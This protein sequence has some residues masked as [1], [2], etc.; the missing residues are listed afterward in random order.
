MNSKGFSRL[1]NKVLGN[2]IKIA[3]ALGHISVGPEHLIVAIAE[4]AECDACAILEKHAARPL[5]E[6]RGELAKQLG[7]GEATR[8]GD[9]DVTAELEG[10]LKY[11]SVC[12][13]KLGDDCVGTEQLLCAAISSQNRTVLSL[14]SKL[15]VSAERVRGDCRPLPAERGP[16][17]FDYDKQRV[18]NKLLEK[19]T[20]DLTARAVCGKLDEV[21]CREEELAR[22]AAILSRRKK[23]NACLVGEPGVGKTAVAEG[24]AARIARGDVPDSLRGKRILSLDVSS[25][26]AGTKY[27]G[28][29]EE[30]FKTTISEIIKEGD[31]IVFID[32]MHTVMGA[33]AA[34]G[35]IDASNILKPLL[36]GSELQVIGATTLAEYAKYVEKDKAFERRFSRVDVPEPTAAQT[37]KI[38]DSQIP[39][40]ERFHSL[41]ISAAA[42]EAAVRLSVRYI[43]DRCLPDKALDLIDEAA[44]E[45]RI[46]LRESGRVRRTPV[47]DEQDVAR[48]V[49]GISGVP[50]G[51]LNTD[52]SARLLGL[53][54]SLR[55][56][57]IGQEDAVRTLSAAIRR[58]RSGLKEAEKPMGCF[59]FCGP[60][61]VGKT[62]VCRALA[63]EL[64][65]D[66]KA[67]LRF[68][69]SEYADRASLS[70]LVGAAPGYVGHGEGGQLTD[71]VR[72]KPY[73]L[74]LFDEAEKACP[75]FFN[76]CLQ[77]LEEGTMTDACGARISF[78][79]CL[80]V[81]TTNLAARRISENPCGLGFARADSGLSEM[82]GMV[83]GELRKFFSPE[84]LG[85]LDETVIFRPLG[86]DDKLEIAK[87]LLGRLSERVAEI[88]YKTEIAEGVAQLICARCAESR[89]GARP[90]KR[91]I[92]TEIERP[93]SELLISGKIKRGERICVAANE[94]TVVVFPARSAVVSRY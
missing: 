83:E 62:E 10:V 84:F 31:I 51:R 5:R 63:A 7:R 56:R 69:M 61:G 57:V 58:S 50:V 70:R 25:M 6:M 68:D 88:G 13:A 78:S 79:N 91:A 86:A 66:E 93:L 90:L 15:G 24:L 19:Y 43:H 39:K 12:S 20:V 3:S 27:R 55:D 2:S 17:L 74:V 28:D 94:D 41:R 23:N 46:E 26:V 18:K 30:R 92:M 11:A 54:A 29:F 53:E 34:E 37:R 89:L 9:D 14:L 73:S 21:I 60:T 1:S 82:R 45:K 72:R 32:E 52:E 85:R 87:L 8:L 38:L 80:V 33:G 77:I 71:A 22:L 4:L 75:E 65:G 16:E 36:S 42:C 48:V 64:F 44:A 67:V 40:L 49:S 76:L 59:L 81:F 35:A 47:L